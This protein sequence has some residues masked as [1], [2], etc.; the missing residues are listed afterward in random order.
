[1]C[2]WCVVV[3]WAALRAYPYAYTALSEANASYGG[4]SGRSPKAVQLKKNAAAGKQLEKQLEQN[5]KKKFGKENVKTQQTFK[6][7]YGNRRA[8]IQINNKGNSFIIE[9]KRGNSRYTKSQRIKDAWIAKN[10]GIKT[11]VYRKK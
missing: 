7:P 8:D 5:M 4:A 10:L 11:Y 9:A 3:L 2:P 6:T 1:M